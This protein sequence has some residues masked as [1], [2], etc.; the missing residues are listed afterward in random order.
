[1]LKRADVRSLLNSV[2]GSEECRTVLEK[3]WGRG[4]ARRLRADTADN[5]VRAA[6]DCTRLDLNWGVNAGGRPKRTFTR[7][8]SSRAT[9]RGIPNTEAL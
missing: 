4:E 7:L 8:P 9:E 3:S 1:M 2:L 5:P 6:A